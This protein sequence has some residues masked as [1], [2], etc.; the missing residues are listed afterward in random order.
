MAHRRRLRIPLVWHGSAAVARVVE[1]SADVVR[2]VAI[3]VVMAGVVLMLVGTASVGSQE[4][5]QAASE[6]YAA[7]PD[8][9]SFLLDRID[10]PDNEPVVG[11]LAQLRPAALLAGSFQ[12]A[13]DSLTEQMRRLVSTPSLM[14]TQ[15]WLSSNF[16]RRR[17]HPLLHVVRPHEGIDVR[18]AAGTPIQ[19]PAAGTIVKAGWEGGYGRLVEIDHGFGIT[20]RYAHTS[21]IFVNVGQR[22]MRGEVIATVGRSGLAE[23][24]HLH[25]EVHVSGRA[26]DPLK[27]V[28]PAVMAD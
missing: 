26:V 13:S 18:A 27:F 8:S 11:L 6:N 28:L 7:A 5:R 21:R 3:L 16:T 12:R 10:Q 1:V 17:Y 23:A 9:M 2:A 19:A 20:T 15:G 24:A 14:P 25:Y 4:Y 22:V